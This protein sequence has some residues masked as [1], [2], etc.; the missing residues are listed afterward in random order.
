MV[1]TLFTID[2]LVPGHENLNRKIDDIVSLKD[3]DLILFHPPLISTYKN[4]A[5]RSDKKRF[6]NSVDYDEL[7]EKLGLWSEELRDAYNNG[8]NVFV[9]L[10]EESKIYRGGESTYISSYSYFPMQ[11]LNWIFRPGETV[12]PTVDLDCFKLFWNSFNESLS[13]KVYFS[14]GNKWHKPFLST[15]DADSFV[16]TIYKGPNAK[17]NIIFLPWITPPLRHI[18]KDHELVDAPQSIKFGNT[19]IKVL[20]DI[21]K[22]L[23][24]INSETSPPEWVNEESFVL[25]S[26]KSIIS[27]IS[28]LDA[29]IESLK[30]QKNDLTITLKDESSMKKLL[31]GK[32]KELEAEVIKALTILGF[33]AENY[34]DSSSE[35]DV[36][37]NYDSIFLLGEIEGKD[38]KPINMDKIRQ[39]NG[40]IEEYYIK[41]Q[42]APKAVLFG[43]ANR[44]ESPINRR[45]FFTD[46]C[47]G[48][49]DL[50]SILLV[51]TTDLFNII[52]YIKENNDEQY[53]ANCRECILNKEKGL[54][55]FPPIPEKILNKSVN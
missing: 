33:N 6:M 55:E 50:R 27:D 16:G 11:L 3:A 29:Q 32:G 1:R 28:K 41:N 48:F 37:F 21:D 34:T 31:Y 15:K 24:N 18:V 52:K 49:A 39:L 40:N 42:Q 26:E 53:I 19:L 22:K 20:F 9:L 54:I 4:V 25:K 10:D 44:L 47:T 12:K 7:K 5:Q 13:Y 23:K 36:I 35:F 43:N 51:K 17:G 14:G 30:K 2:Y 46:H 38:S 45:E 8:K